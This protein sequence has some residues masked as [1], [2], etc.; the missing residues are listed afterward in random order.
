MDV[1]L[2]RRESKSEGGLL[3]K[4]LRKRVWPK[5][6][7]VNIYH[8]PDYTGTYCHGNCVITTPTGPPLH[9]HK[10]SGQVGLDVNRCGRRLPKGILVHCAGQ[11]WLISTNVLVLVQWSIITGTMVHRY[12]YNGP[13]VLVQ[14]SIVTGTM[15]HHYW[16]NGPLV[17]VQWYWYNGP[18]L[19][20]T[21]ERNTLL[22]EQLKR[23]ILRLLSE[24]DLCYYQGLHDVVLT[25]L[26]VLD[27]ED[28]TFA[29]TNV[30]VK[31]HLRYEAI[32]LFS[33][34]TSK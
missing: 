27:E 29:L 19:E 22:Q 25:F 26:L 1:E 31:H 6:L 24:N 34:E 13:L 17:L 2:L 14:W 3:C 15:V 11:V 10:E 18:L 28:L 5:L 16:Y 23:V 7:G 33:R 21:L 4:E 20:F 8:I 9:K 32:L 12:W 30:L